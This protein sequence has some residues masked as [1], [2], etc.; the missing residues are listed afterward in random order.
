MQRRGMDSGHLKVGCDPKERER[1]YEQWVDRRLREILSQDLLVQADVPPALDKE[2]LRTYLGHITETIGRARGTPD[3]F[4]RMV[5]LD[6][7]TGDGPG[8]RLGDLATI[9]AA[10]ERSRAL[11][12]RWISYPYRFTDY[13]D[14]DRWGFVIEPVPGYFH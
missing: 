9:I 11:G 4:R 5:I 14:V 8:L 12:K 2:G 3:R 1:F 7:A 10:V 13:R 6:T